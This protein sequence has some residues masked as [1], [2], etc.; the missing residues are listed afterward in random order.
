[1]VV[2]DAEG[3]S[4]ETHEL[5]NMAAVILH[6]SCSRHVFEISMFNDSPLYLAV[7]GNAWDYW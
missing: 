4:Y 5:D 3:D 1:M 6:C 7:S 2:T